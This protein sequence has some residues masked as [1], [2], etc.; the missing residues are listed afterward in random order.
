MYDYES[1]NWKTVRAYASLEF[2]KDFIPMTDQ[3]IEETIEKRKEKQKELSRKYAEQLYSEYLEKGLISEK[4]FQKVLQAYEEHPE[5]FVQEVPTEEYHEIS[6]I[7]DSELEERKLEK[8][9]R[10]YQEE[11]E[12]V[13]EG[14][15]NEI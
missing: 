1:E 12:E 11:M 4:E 10:L 6:Q 2:L 5:I 9:K 3:E 7:L 14:Y 8:E 13:W 15:I